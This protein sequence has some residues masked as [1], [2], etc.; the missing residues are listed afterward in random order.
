[1][2]TEYFTIL[3][4]V[5]GIVVTYLI[6][7]ITF[8]HQIK[9]NIKSVFSTKNHFYDVV[10]IEI[11]RQSHGFLFQSAQIVCKDN[12]QFFA[13]GQGTFD[14]ANCFTQPLSRTVNF[15]YWIDPEFSNEPSSV[16]FWFAMSKKTHR[17]R[18]IRFKFH[19]VKFPY[20]SS[21]YIP[22]VER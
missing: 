2:K 7:H 3:V 12:C 22:V 11:K 1:M 14:E 16:V 8:R 4:T 10:M 19:S 21:V 13:F 9:P 6:A 20:K 17:K 15:N 18:G 5:L